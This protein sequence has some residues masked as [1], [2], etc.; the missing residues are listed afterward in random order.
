[1]WLTIQC[2]LQFPVLKLH[3][4]CPM[5]H[6]AWTRQLL[7]EMQI[8]DRSQLWVNSLV[9]RFLLIDIHSHNFESKRIWSILWCN[10]D[11]IWRHFSHMVGKS[12]WNVSL[13]LYFTSTKAMDELKYNGLGVTLICHSM[14]LYVFVIMQQYNWLF[15]MRDITLNEVLVVSLNGT[16][17]PGCWH[18]CCRYGVR[19]RCLIWFTL[20][21]V[22][23]C[24]CH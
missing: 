22:K 15:W 14:T 11:V 24:R 23:Y 12:T 6:G 3:P 8:H 16:L 17:L 18:F 20:P 10:D 2:H 9:P 13:L 21:R 1:M 19:S 4:L 5:R 7:L